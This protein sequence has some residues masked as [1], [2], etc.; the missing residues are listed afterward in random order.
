[1]TSGENEITYPP[2]YGFHNEVLSARKG[3]KAGKA[4]WGR[5]C[6]GEGGLSIDI[7]IQTGGSGTDRA[8]EKLLQRACER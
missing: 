3:Q 8:Q 5:A 2:F 6:N 1:M 7:S 4:R